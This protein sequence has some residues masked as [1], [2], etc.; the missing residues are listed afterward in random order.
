MLPFARKLGYV[1]HHM[2]INDLLNGASY[3]SSSELHQHFPA[4]VYLLSC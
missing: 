1:L 4:F 3:D 2:F